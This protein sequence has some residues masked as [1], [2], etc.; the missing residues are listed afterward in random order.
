MKVNNHKEKIIKSYTY[1]DVSKYGNLEANDEGIIKAFLEKPKAE[2]TSSRKAVR[3]CLKFYTLT[4][5]LYYIASSLLPA[6]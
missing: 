6:G 3:K 5:L 1:T 2:E 4:C